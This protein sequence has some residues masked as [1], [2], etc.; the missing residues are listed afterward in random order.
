M[1]RER[2]E[3]GRTESRTSTWI[4]NPLRY[5]LKCGGGNNPL[6]PVPTNSIST[7]LISSLNLKRSGERTRSGSNDFK[8]LESLLLESV[9]FTVFRRRSNV[10]HVHEVV[11]YEYRGREYETVSECETGERGEG[12]DYDHGTLFVYCY[13]VDEAVEGR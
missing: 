9:P 7:S 5:C 10:P 6:A 2:G 8:N 3:G 13:H 1:Y 12:C 4:P 11:D